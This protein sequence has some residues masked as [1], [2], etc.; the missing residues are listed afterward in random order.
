MRLGVVPDTAPTVQQ[1]GQ[2]QSRDQEQVN[3]HL[4]IT[5]QVLAHAHELINELLVNI[6]RD[7]IGWLVNTNSQDVIKGS[8]T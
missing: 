6:T 3:R 2:Q 5:G 4:L 7:F 1:V 8:L